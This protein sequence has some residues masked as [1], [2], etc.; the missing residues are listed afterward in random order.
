MNVK[1]EV[2]ERCKAMMERELSDNQYKMIVNRRK[3]NDLAKEQ[4]IL[5]A[6]RGQLYLLL[7]DFKTK[8]L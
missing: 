2:F 7:K 3:I 6:Q 1:K 5:K 8:Q 4:R